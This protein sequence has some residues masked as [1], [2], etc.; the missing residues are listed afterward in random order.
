MEE[1]DR[2]EGAQEE[3]SKS[4]G[5]VS[6]KEIPSNASS[7]QIVVSPDQPG[8]K[9]DCTDS[10]VDPGKLLAKPDSGFW[11]TATDIELRECKEGEDWEE[12]DGRVAGDDQPC[13]FTIFFVNSITS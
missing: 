10:D 9:T 4:H 1:E 7:I 6:V 13:S 11:T 2:Q 8:N 3:G 5:N 12:E